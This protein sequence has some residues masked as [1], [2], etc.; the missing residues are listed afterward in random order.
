MKPAGML[1]AAAILLT[2]TAGAFAQ[3]AQCGG[4]F[5][6]FVEGVRAEA[7]A[8]G[9]SQDAVRRATTGLRI[10]QRVLQRDRAQ[11]VFQQAWLTFADRMIS[12]NRL[13]R[14][15]QELQR[16]ADLFRRIEAETGVPGAVLTAF[17]GLETDF[18]G[19][20]GDFETLPALA[21]LA[22]DCR[23][24]ELFRPHL[25]AAIRLVDLGYLEP[26]QMR[27]AWAGELGQTQLLPEDYIR[28][29]TDADNNGRIDLIRDRADAL[30]TTGKFIQ[31][32]GWR[33]GEPWIEEVRLPQNFPLERAAVYSR[34]PR[35][36]FAELGVTKADGSALERD[37]LPSSI[38][39]P[40]GAGGPAFLTFPNFDI[41]I[42]WNNSLIYTLSAAYFATRLDGAPRVTAGNPRPG[43]DADQMVRLQQRLQARGHDVGKI[44]GI[45]GAGT[46]AAVRTEQLRLGLPAD[47][48]PTAELLAALN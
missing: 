7:I 1:A 32:L 14:G 45:L 35:S 6:Q 23:R 17:W 8:Q 39:L 24:P 19:F 16:N 33:R 4:D 44:D 15:R 30:F 29:G 31:N 22:H 18:G 20:L 38:V 9:M 41:Y 5:G 46:R 27:G 26:S 42:E 34:E 3:G 13:D 43:L 2:G 28:F 12:Q 48:W 10:D 36:A 25:I 40:Q 11:G 21:T 47:A 37:N